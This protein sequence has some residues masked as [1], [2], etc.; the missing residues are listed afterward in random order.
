M[1][2][3]IALVTGAGK[4]LGAEIARGLGAQGWRVIVHHNA[5]G[6]EAEAVAAGIR[7]A[8][9]AAQTARFDLE[10]VS[11][12]ADFLRGL[13]RVDA[14]VNSASLFHDDRPEAFGP[15]LFERHLKINLMAPCLLA[16]AMAEEHS[17]RASGCVINIL[18]QKLFNLN[19][20]FFT[21][22]LSKYALL[23]ATRTMAMAFAP[24]VRVNAV[25][26]GLVLPSYKQ[27]P[28]RFARAH[29]A[30]PMQGGAAPADIVRA[31]GFILD[32]PAMTGETIILD[33][34]EH[35]IARERDVSYLEE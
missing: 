12:A 25:A 4:R 24:R 13:G 21:Y 30:N 18:D 14:L 31:V 26:P 20:D 32:T 29:R 33:G 5:S 1:S 19:P 10:D 7:K 8:G 27:T 3:R 34:G 17:E 15:E 11:G 9:G 28:E 6:D 16:A 2:A 23:G 22:T 35:L